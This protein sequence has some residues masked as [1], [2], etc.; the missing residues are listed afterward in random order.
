MTRS[1]LT[2]ALKE[3]RERKSVLLV[4]YSQ[5][6]SA[7]RLVELARVYPQ[8]QSSGT[9]VIAI[10]LP[11]A[12]S[13]P[14]LPFSVVTDG[15]QEA[16]TAYLLF[17]RTLSDPGK[18]VLGE[19]PSHMEFLIDRFGYVRARWLPQEDGGGATDDW[20]DP[21]F[22]L[23]QIERIAREPRILPPPDDHVH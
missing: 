14:S 18:T 15:A 1:G 12:T 8:L 23:S 13:S 3:Y 9:E 4:F 10:A 6:F 2:A 11:G 22:L 17:R 5:P 21:K 16:A 20:Y 7:K 19:P